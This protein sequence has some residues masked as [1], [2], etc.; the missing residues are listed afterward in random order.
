MRIIIVGAG[1]TGL[2]AA[3]LL[4]QLKIE[5]IVLE[6]RSGLT[7]E[8]RAISIDDEGLR[9]CQMAG[10]HKLLMEQ[11]NLNLPALYLS[12]RHVLACIA[13]TEQPNGFPSIS[14]FH[15]PDLEET[16]SIG[17]TRFPHVQL[18]FE[19][20]VCSVVQNDEQV[21]VIVKTPS[22]PETLFVAD[23]VLACDG[24]RSTIRQSLA[25]PLSTPLFP[26]FGSGKRSGKSTREKSSH[27]QRW[28]VI[29]GV[30]SEPGEPAIHFFCQ[31]SRPVVAVS[32]PNGR[33]RWELM[34]FP[35]EF[36]DQQEKLI[37]LL[38]QTCE[39][40]QSTQLHV[41]TLTIQRQAIYTFQSAV[42]E[43]LQVGRVFLLGDAA[44]MMPPF[45]GQGMNSGFRDAA[46]LCWKFGLIQQRSATSHILASYQQERLP[47]VKQMI[48]FSTLL[49]RLIMTGNPGIA[50]LRDRFFLTLQKCP[51]LYQNVSELKIKPHTGYT[52]GLVLST[53]QKWV[54]RLVPQPEII[55]MQGEHRMLDEVL[56]PG[57]ALLTLYNRE[58][59]SLV[60]LERPFWQRMNVRRI[61]LY[62]LNQRQEVKQLEGENQNCLVNS[63]HVEWLRKHRDHYWL[64]RPD[65]YVLAI[66][67]VEEVA[68]IEKR[69]EHLFTHS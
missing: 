43:R 59:K 48:L 55:T 62:A 30:E 64:I 14:T 52:H 46:N 9:C 63:E 1:P 65:R 61:C 20:T 21:Q 53:A 31:P 57:F 29:D 19:H 50:W 28:L 34:L 32:A 15:Q 40:H 67:R 56:G 6:R 22:Q 3:N 18:H 26:G 38:K 44:H 42:A 13:P 23:Y 69:L 33:R 39:R 45:G 16:L 8:P 5:T 54:G 2:L 11:M 27:N 41:S 60:W 49:G 36:I 17:L 12:H 66:F 25:I 24:G 58:E 4:G 35:D 47:H 10:L 68:E 7:L 37:K 51:W